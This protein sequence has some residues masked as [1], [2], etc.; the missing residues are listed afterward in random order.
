MKN[1]SKR[2][3]GSVVAVLFL[4]I[5]TVFLFNVFG[6]GN[7]FVLASAHGANAETMTYD[8]E[9]MAADIEE[10]G[11]YTYEEL[12]ALVPV[13]EIMFDAVNGQYLKVAVGKGMITLEQIGELVDRYSDLFV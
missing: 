11:L 9:G 7:F 6:S 2:I 1:I 13:P 10:Y 12:N 5:V 8:A 3:K 4:S